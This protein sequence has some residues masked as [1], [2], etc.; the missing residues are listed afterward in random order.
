[1][2]KPN[3]KSYKLPGGGTKGIPGGPWGTGPATTANPTL[4]TED[5]ASHATETTTKYSCEEET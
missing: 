4:D 1:M 5:S 2:S 3:S